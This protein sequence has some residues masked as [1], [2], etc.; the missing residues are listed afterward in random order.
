MTYKDAL[1]ILNEKIGEYSE[2][3]GY[4]PIQKDDGDSPSSDGPSR[5]SESA[6]MTLHNKTQ[7]RTV[8]SP[9]FTARAHS[10]AN[11][12]KPE[13]T[14]PLLLPK[15]PLAPLKPLKPMA[16]AKPTMPVAPVK[17]LGFLP[18]QKL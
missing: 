3:S 4:R 9:K 17:P 12:A 2:A 8:S 13:P 1:K 14:K 18:K 7:A 6:K 11:S 10:T 5:R 16:P 15:P